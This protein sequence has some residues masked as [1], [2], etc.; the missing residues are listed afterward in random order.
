ML[1]ENS[2]FEI[3]IIYHFKL[4]LLDKD[5]CSI[6]NGG[7][8][9]TCVN[10]AGSYLCACPKGYTLSTNKFTCIGN[11]SAC[12][13]VFLPKVVCYL[14]S[15]CCWIVLIFLNASFK[16]GKTVTKSSTK[17]TGNII[18]CRYEQINEWEEQFFY[19][20]QDIN[21]CQFETQPCD[22]ICSNSIG[23][24]QCTCKDGYLLQSDNKTCS[25]KYVCFLKSSFKSSL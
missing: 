5:E 3:R 2:N 21:E 20:V 19:F 16:K 25:C 22:H 8:S 7:C 14:K 18:L 12:I 23:G 9:H 15:N 11:Y 13:F 4:L 24:F 10:T 1:K 6:N 17:R